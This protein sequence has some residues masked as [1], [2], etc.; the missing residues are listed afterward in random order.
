M[1]IYREA[2]IQIPFESGTRFVR[3]AFPLK[4]ANIKYNQ[5]ANVSEL[6]HAM[7]KALWCRNEMFKRWRPTP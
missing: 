2:T 4:K 6:E 1:V 5:L 7:V 3:S